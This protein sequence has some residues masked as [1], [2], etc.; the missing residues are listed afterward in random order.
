MAKIAPQTDR[1]LHDMGRKIGTFG[2]INYRRHPENHNYIVFNFNSA[3]EAALFEAELAKNRIWFERATEEVTRR[4]SAFSEPK[5]A[6]E[7]VYLYAV[8]E[9]NL[10]E[11]IRANGKVHTQFKKSVFSNKWLRYSLLIFFG[12]L[13]AFAIT[14]YVKNSQKVQPE[15]ASTERDS[16]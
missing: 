10:N 2:L 7:T 8:R 15:P 14:G 6:T 16:L 9:G 13:L 4:A 5:N 11:A 12:V 1:I 3:E